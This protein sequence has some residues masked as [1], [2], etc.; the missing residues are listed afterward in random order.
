MTRIKITRTSVLSARPCDDYPPDLIHELI[1][2]E[3]LTIREVAEAEQIPIQDRV[4]ALTRGLEVPQALRAAVDREW[5]LV[6]VSVARR[7]LE[8]V[9]APDPRSVRAVDVA[10]RYALG[11]ATAEELREAEAAAWEAWATA[12]ELRE[13]EAARAA[14][15]SA[16][17]ASAARASAAWASSAS[18]A[19][20]AAWAARAALAARAAAAT[21]TAAADYRLTLDELV[22]RLEALR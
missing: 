2:P 7:S 19:V 15:A 17:W 16:A 5:R 4:W 22:S 1:P 21:A 14:W 12:E 13:A 11:E 3:G 8:P 20:A 10:E 6:A 18:A 9:P